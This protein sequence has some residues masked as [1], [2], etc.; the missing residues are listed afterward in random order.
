MRS[1]T[2]HLS[3]EAGLLSRLEPRDRQ[4]VVDALDSLIQALTRG[5]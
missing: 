2:R 1:T 4:A 5:R 3:L